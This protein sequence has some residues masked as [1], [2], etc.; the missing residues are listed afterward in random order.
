MRSLNDI[1]LSQGLEK[2]SVAQEGRGGE[3]GGG[4][5]K[6]KMEEMVRTMVQKEISKYENDQKQD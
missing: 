5:D 3:G 6:E 4:V 2:S 1:L